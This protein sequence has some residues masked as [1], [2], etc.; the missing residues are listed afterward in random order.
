MHHTNYFSARNKGAVLKGWFKMSFVLPIVLIINDSPNYLIPTFEIADRTGDHSESVFGVQ[1][2][3][4]HAV[5]GLLF[6]EV[7]EII[8]QNI[9]KIWNLLL[10]KKDGRCTKC[11]C[12]R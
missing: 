3:V 6:L 8:P 4:F 12:C 9:W 7:V 2:S 5:I 1:A 11:I 10:E